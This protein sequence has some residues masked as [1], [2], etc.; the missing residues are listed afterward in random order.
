MAKE[1]DHDLHFL[2]IPLMSQ[3]H[4][5]PLTDFGKLLAQRG[6]VVSI[7]T[8]P[9]NFTRYKAAVKHAVEAGLKIQM[10]PLDFPGQEAG[11]PQGCENMDSLTSMDLAKEFFIA[12]EMLAAPLEQLMAEL[13][14]KPSCIM[15][16]NA[17]PWTQRVADKF[18]I[19]RYIFETISCFTLLCSHIL[20][21]DET[22]E[23]RAAAT[24]SKPFLVP[25]IPHRIEFTKAQLPE[26]KKKSSDSNNI[27]SI[28]EQIKRARHS[29]RATVVNSFEEMEGGYAEGYRKVARTLWCIGPASLC[30][31][32]HA[33]K[34]DRGNK[35]S[36]DEQH[37]ISWLDAK[38]PGSVIYTCFGSLCH[39]SA[40]QIKE[41]GLGLEASGFA[42]I[43][44]IRGMDSSAE[45]EK[46]LAEE[47]LEERVEGRGLIIR[48]W[49]PQVLILSHPSV[50]GFLTHC[51]WNSTLEGVSAGMP[52]ITWPMFAEQFYNEKFIVQV[53]KIGVRVGVEVGVGGKPGAQKEDKKALVKWDRV[54][55]SIQNL[56]E[57]DEEG[58]ERRKRAKK[59][60]EMARDALEQQGSSYKNIT[61]LIQD[62]VH[63][64]QLW[65]V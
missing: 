33:E 12:C 60:A 46:W 18:K 43:W 19:P 37:C 48:G 36:I 45:V 8:T 50:G 61:L 7:I 51:G 57:E 29:A 3:S 39:I 38:E 25:D 6:L 47:K 22:Q 53:L 55:K 4:I 63:A 52:M 58:R 32:E 15:S 24:D 17:L 27:E 54:M 30:N 13:H 21:L 26:T 64:Q 23:M 40:T 59:L 34:L 44:I 11:L 49:A 1:I 35:A 9:H 2:V 31:K 56:M 65:A 16:T 5:I 41:I 10:I 62:V 28:I 14:P 42:F 20:S